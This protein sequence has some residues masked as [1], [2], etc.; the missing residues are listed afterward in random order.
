MIFETDL[1][2][3]QEAILQEEIERELI[4]RCTVA[5]AGFDV[6][7]K[8]PPDGSSIDRKNSVKRSGDSAE[9]VIVD[10]RTTSKN[11]LAEGIEA[12]L[13]AIP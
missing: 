7:R 11:L 1:D 8:R 4:V 6:L 2:K 12:Q 9:A 13:N 10:Y 3:R 5:A